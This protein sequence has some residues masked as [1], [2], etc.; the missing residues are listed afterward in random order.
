MSSFVVC[1][2]GTVFTGAS[3][4]AVIAMP[5]VADPGVLMPS[6]AREG[7]RSRGCRVVAAVLIRHGTQRRLVV[8]DRGR[9]CSVSTPVPLL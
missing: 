5:R 4:T 3:F 7:N 9:T 6:V 8:S 1:G 2:P